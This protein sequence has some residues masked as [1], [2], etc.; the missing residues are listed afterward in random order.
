MCISTADL[1]VFWNKV[2]EIVEFDIQARTFPQKCFNVQTLSVFEISAAVP[3]SY[4]K[5]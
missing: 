1:L 4:R 2:N 3:G 5:K